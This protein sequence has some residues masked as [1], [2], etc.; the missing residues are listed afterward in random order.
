LVI[1]VLCLRCKR[2]AS[3]SPDVQTSTTS[4]PRQLQRTDPK[5]EVSSYNDVPPQPAFPHKTNSFNYPTH[6]LQPSL[7]TQSDYSSVGNFE[8]GA[9][10]SSFNRTQ[11]LRQSSNT[12]SLVHGDAR[13]SAMSSTYNQMSQ[14][15]SPNYPLQYPVGYPQPIRPGSQSPPLNTSTG[16]F[17]VNNH[18]ALFSQTL[19]PHQSSNADF[20]VYGDARSSAAMSPADR[21]MTTIPETLLPLPWE[22]G[23]GNYL[24]PPSQSGFQPSPINAPAADLAVRDPPTPFNQTQPSHTSSN[25]DF[26][27]YGDAQT[28]VVT[29]VEYMAAGPQQA[30]PLPQKTELVYL[31]PPVQPESQSTSSSA[32]KVAVSKPPVSESQSMMSASAEPVVAAAGQTVYQPPTQFIVHT[33]VDDVVPNANGLV[34]LPPQYSEHRGVGVL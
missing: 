17:T 28:S 33:D 14:P 2:R 15:M 20:A 4:H 16:N 11:H 19:H 34:E 3:R 10:P 9:P 18:P 25:T 30:P 22:T 21:R 7:G 23:N 8:A 31:T 13:S 1:L 6:S 29:P 27:V 24:G 12:D 26:V 5:Y 32:G